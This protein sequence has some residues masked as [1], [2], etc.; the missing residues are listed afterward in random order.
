MAAEDGNLSEARLAEL[1]ALADGSL[2][3]AKRAEVEGAVE[4][5][6]ELRAL[7]DQQRAAVAAV[8]A[9]D[10]PAPASL[11]ARV[12]ATRRAAERPRRPGLALAGGF[13]A[14][15]AATILAVV[16]LDGGGRADPTVL[17]AASLAERGTSAPAPAPDGRQ[18]KL[19]AASVAGVPFP[20]YAVRFGWRASGTRADE[21]AG[22]ATQTVYYDLRD[23]RI[24]YTIVS[25]AA[26]QWPA[27]ARRTV[28][29]G[30][31]LRFVE[32][33]A[34]TIVTWLR[35]GHTCVLSGDSVARG[36]LLELAAWKPEGT[37][38]S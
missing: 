24:A 3:P 17:E 30:V 31:T 34:E 35:D 10:T 28:R 32:R 4:R 23:R 27:G 1:T 15:L 7:F 11:R 5:S 20:D 18:P 9:L 37:D 33:D 2:A 19:L 26:L 8:W 22:R 14:A 12:E 6:P 25:G 29:D 36:E 21:L 16:I 38:R 13:A